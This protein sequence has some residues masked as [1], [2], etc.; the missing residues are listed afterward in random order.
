MAAGD[1]AFVGRRSLDPD[2][3]AAL[4]SGRSHAG[5]EADAETGEGMLEFVTPLNLPDGRYV[6]R[7]TY[8]EG[9]LDAQL[10]GLKR[11]MLLLGLLTLLV[12]GGVFY[13]VGGRALMRSHRVALTRATRDGLTDLPNQ[14]AFHDDLEQAVAAA[15]RGQGAVALAV[16][17]LDDFK[18]VNDKHGHPQGD[19]LLR[20]VARRAAGRPARLIA[21]TARAAT[22]SPPCSRTPTRRAPGSWRADSTGR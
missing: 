11:T 16:I 13:L 19:A 14:R 7:T 21:C 4:T 8:D 5:A 2:V 15:S 12:G 3:R 17:D 18:F 9:A 20:R 6:Y 22:S 1:D 10:A